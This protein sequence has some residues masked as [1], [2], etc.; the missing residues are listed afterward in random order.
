MSWGF[1]PLDEKLGLLPGAYA[2]RLQ[3]LIV[4]LGTW[5]P[6]ERVPEAL[7]F[8]SGVTVSAETARVLTEQAGAALV[9][10]QEAE[11]ERLA[12][13]AP[14][15]PAGPA[16][17]QLSADGTMVPLV[18]GEWSEVRLLSIGTI[19]RRMTTEGVEVPTCQ[20]LTYFARLAD[21]VTFTRLAVLET[22]ARGTARAGVVCAVVDGADWLQTFIT[23]H[24][25]D[26]VRILDFPHAVEH[27]STAAH[28][29]YRD[30][31]QAR[32]WLDR[33]VPRLKQGEPADVLAALR[34]LPVPSE[35]AGT[36]RD[37]VVAYLEKR[38]K[39][40]RYA[41]FRAQGYPIGSG[42]VESGNKLVIQARLKGSGMH[43]ARA[44]VNPMVALRAADA[45]GRW[46]S[47]W[48]L[49]GQQRHATHAERRQDRARQR[50]ETRER[51][52]QEA[53]AAPAAIAASAAAPEEAPIDLRDP[54]R[55]TKQI[56]DGRPAP[57]HPWR[58]S[59]SSEPQS[60]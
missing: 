3:Q 8:L 42:S 39:Q 5:L 46:T 59:L 36:T 30:A 10:A 35:E 6:F 13:E 31:A 18:G 51:E 60:A 43:W 50:R 49:I 27:L 38:R 48:H 58:A 16:L 33:W 19:G 7:T 52:R 25:A 37:G 57:T 17:Q 23:L 22:H 54:A 2:P 12:R 56:V 14:P 9:A 34:A 55:Q 44:N 29:A 53:A 41:H 45:S 21:A 32:A 1:F 4:R 28:A 24:R 47:T 11:V 20:E 15:S 26:A 40:I